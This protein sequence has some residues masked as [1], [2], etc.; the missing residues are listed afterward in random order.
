MMVITP[1]F[2]SIQVPEVLIGD[3]RD[4][5]V[6]DLDLLFA[7]Q[8]EQEIEG[9]LE[10]IQAHRVGQ[11]TPPSACGGCGA[12]QLQVLLEV[13]EPGISVNGE[14]FGK[15]IPILLYIK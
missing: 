3:A 1:L 14:C 11:R 5:Y 8:V 9:P 15:Y 12:P 13:T 10:E 6:R 2:L 4:G 7:D